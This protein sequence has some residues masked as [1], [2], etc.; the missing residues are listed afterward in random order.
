M[1]VMGVIHSEELPVH[2]LPGN[3]LRGLATRSRGSSEVALWNHALEPGAESPPHWHDHDQVIYVLAGRGRIVVG[4]EEGALSAGDVVVAPARIL[5][6]VRAAADEGL[7][8]LVAMPATKN[9]P[10]AALASRY[11]SVAGSRANP[12]RLLPPDGRSL[13]VRVH[14]LAHNAPAPCK[15][16][17]E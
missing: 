3:R 1:N 2:E 17:K 6:Q 13:A 9:R 8:T 10:Q 14:P 12:V 15:A 16:L 4:D 7:D 11:I 5:H